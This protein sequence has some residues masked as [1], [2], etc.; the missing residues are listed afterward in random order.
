[1]PQTAQGGCGPAPLTAGY[2]AA[3][4]FGPPLRA[5]ASALGAMNLLI[6]GAREGR[7]W[8][9]QVALRPG[10]GARA[11]DDPCRQENAWPRNRFRP[12]KSA[13]PSP[14]LRASTAPWRR[15]FA[16]PRFT[17]S[18]AMKVTDHT[19]VPAQLGYLL[20]ELRRAGVTTYARLAAALNR[21]GLRPARGHWN[22]HQLYLL[23]RRHRR[24]HPAARLN[25]GRAL[26]SRRA[27][28][29]RRLIGR[30]KRRGLKKASL[31]AGALNARGSTTPRHGRLWTARSVS[32]VWQG[33]RR[34][35]GLPRR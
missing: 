10:P 17:H 1:M 3:G 14:Y 34:R 29:A 23:M 8:L 4:L 6:K 18:Q 2:P 15:R 32:R 21:Q 25:A 19:P 26:Y 30:L 31:I 24:A 33:S 22:A 12:G 11:V 9:T 13:P 20:D 28:E 27:E 16:Y 7:N 35:R 5:A